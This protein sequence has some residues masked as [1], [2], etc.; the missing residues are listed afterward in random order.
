MKLI[1]LAL[2]AALQERT[3]DEPSGDDDLEKQNARKIRDRVER[4]FGIPFCEAFDTKK[5]TVTNRGLT[6]QVGDRVFLH[7][8]GDGLE[9]AAAGPDMIGVGRKYFGST[10]PKYHEENL[11]VLGRLLAKAYLEKTA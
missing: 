8:C 6:L 3:R 11:L 10:E 9:V 7:L 5:V 2:I 1:D 4:L